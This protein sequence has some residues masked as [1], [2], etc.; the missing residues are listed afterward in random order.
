MSSVR[1]L[2][3]LLMPSLVIKNGMANRL[4]CLKVLQDCWIISIDL[5]TRTKAQ[6]TPSTGGSESGKHNKQ[7][8]PSIK[9]LPE[10]GVS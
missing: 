10:F 8:S 2:M 9:V 4:I 5:D 3:R 1:P 6:R 7:T